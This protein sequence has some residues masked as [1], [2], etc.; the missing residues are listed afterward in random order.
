VSAGKQVCVLDAAVLLEAGWAHMVHEVWVAVLPEE[1]V[2]HGHNLPSHW[3]IY[4][5][6]LLL[7]IY[8]PSVYVYYKVTFCRLCV[9]N[10]RYL[11]I[12]VFVF[13]FLL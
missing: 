5:C 1:E 7:G 12:Y 6:T 2:R 10:A 13:L 4:T 9:D 8:G 11:V 3:L